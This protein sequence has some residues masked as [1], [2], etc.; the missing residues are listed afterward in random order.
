MTFKHLSALALLALLAACSRSSSPDTAA[1]GNSG[2]PFNEKVDCTGTQADRKNAYFGDLHVHTLYSVDAYFF[3]GLNGPREAFRIGKGEVGNLPT[4]ETD[5]YTA[6]RTIQL[7]RPLDFAATSDHSDFLGNW[8]LLCQ[9]NGTLPIGVNPACNL[10]GD[11][12]R[13]NI[14]TI[15]NGGQPPAFTALTAGVSE[16]PTTASPWQDEL[17]I[18]DEENVPCTF[19][20]FVGY[21][22]TSQKFDQMIHRNVY[23]TGSN[24]PQDVPH[25]A[26]LEDLIAIATGQ[27]TSSNMNDDWRLYDY[28]E[29]NCDP[30]QGCKSIA[31]P[32]NPNQSS[33]GMYLARDP[34][35][36]LPP[37]RDG[38]PLTLADAKLRAKYDNV[39]E[40]F[41]HKGNS[42]CAVGLGPYETKFDPAC[43]LELA[44]NVCVGSPQDPPECKKVCTGN[45]AT[46]PDF[47][48]LTTVATGVCEQAGRDGTSGPVHKCVAPLD[49]ARNI[50]A[51]GLAIRDTLGVNP[52]RMGF[53]GSSDTH[54][55]DPG[56]VGENGF[57][58]HGGVLDNGPRT[59]LG[60]W[61]CDGQNQDPTNPANC[62]NRQFLDRARLFNPGGL[63]GAW[64][65]E[66]TREAI[67]SA[68]KRGETFA[69]SGPRIRIR[70]LAM[71]TKPPA[72]ICDQ[73]SAGHNPVDA[74]E[75]AG[76]VM[77][78]NLPDN[79]T[80]AA[81]YIVV[82]AQQ[83]PGGAT[84]GLPLQKLDLIKGW[85][86]ASGQPHVKVF[87]A[88]AKTS[89]KV[90]MPS[91]AD[92]SVKPAG[93]PERLCT[94]WRDPK[95][96]PREQA[97]YYA[98]A[99]E[100]PSCRWSTRLCTKN[101]VD[102]SKLDPA[103]GIFPADSGMQ[104]FEGC[105]GITGTVGSFSGRNRFSTI[106]ERAWA[107]PVW[108]VPKA[109]P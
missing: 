27:G 30:A 15:I 29:Q 26:T 7:D 84:P 67:W 62:S 98:R 85:S 102:C 108:F 90:S 91:S 3:N 92:C 33:G 99:F 79:P 70:T 103:N 87:D 80:P 78:G 5:A 22:W 48:S 101:N 19:S 74:G 40:I 60:Y 23:Y 61:T 96:N 88:I 42:E 97:Y 43:T 36:G 2:T 104:G 11:Y 63:A 18:S 56:N 68:M 109:Q 106:T 59:Q 35:T 53:I 82:W 77:G 58:G 38:A 65:P 20:T 17:R 6:G 86:D 72:D 105:C 75:I 83:D 44:K 21:E 9:V 25:V 45:P 10:V 93:H 66:N 12:L 13:Q 100:I 50:L 41:Q 54:N 52:M 71:W 24:L 4:G 1:G 107:S 31:I 89:S 8:R 69:T 37:G 49:M 81:P 73:L 14:T 39:I 57:P 55:G 16:L 64:A 51:D 94:V 47:C 28:L 34:A 76:A 46:D 32:H 95:F